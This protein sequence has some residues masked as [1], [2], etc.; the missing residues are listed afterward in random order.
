MMPLV[1]SSGAMRS[2][3]SCAREAF[4]KNASASGSIRPCG[5]T[6]ILRTASPNAVPPGSR[7]TNTS[8]PIERSSRARPAISVVLPEPSIPSKEIN[9]ASLLANAPHRA[10]GPGS[11]LLCFCGAED[12]HPTIGFE[13]SAARLQP[14]F[15]GDLMLHAADVRRLRRQFDRVTVE[16]DLIDGFFRFTHRDLFVVDR[17]Q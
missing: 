10:F 3:T 14:V 16:Q 12:L 1:L 11:S 5:S 6:K 15:L 7:V 2:A 17:R 4:I 8:A 13:A 9:T